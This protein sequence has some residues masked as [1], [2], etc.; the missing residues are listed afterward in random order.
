M[1]QINLN[2][3]INFNPL[4]LQPN[5]LLI[6]VPAINI[7]QMQPKFIQNNFKN[8]NEEIIDVIFKKDSTLKV[9]LLHFNPQEKIS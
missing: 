4:M 3:N 5:P 2:N 9:T 8:N 7:N 1:N 6:N